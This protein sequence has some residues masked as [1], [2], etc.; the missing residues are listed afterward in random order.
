MP[1]ALVAEQWE[2]GFA[3]LQK[4]HEREGHCRV[5]RK[6]QE[7][8]FKLGIWIGTQRA[9]KDRLSRNKIKRLNALGFV[10]KAK[11]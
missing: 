4:F 5:P 3:A 10:W 9:K 11:L 7:D 8:R 6:H 1:S 2:K